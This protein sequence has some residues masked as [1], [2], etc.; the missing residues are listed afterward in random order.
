MNDDN[1]IGRDPMGRLPFWAAG[2]DVDLDYGAYSD[3][4]LQALFADM[5]V[6]ERGIRTALVG[7]KRRHRELV[8]LLTEQ[9]RAVYGRNLKGR[10]STKW[11]SGA[12]GDQA[13]VL[14]PGRTWGDKDRRYSLRETETWTGIQTQLNAAMPNGYANP[15]REASPDTVLEVCDVCGAPIVNGKRG[16]QRRYC[17]RD[18]SHKQ[19]NHNARRRADPEKSVKARVA[20]EQQPGFVPEFNL[21]TV[22]VWMV[23]DI[24][25]QDWLRF[26][27]RPGAGF[28]IETMQAIS[29]I[30]TVVAQRQIVDDSFD[31]SQEAVAAA[32]A[33]MFRKQADRK[34]TFRYLAGG[35][36]RVDVPINGPA[37]P[38]PYRPAFSPVKLD[39]RVPP[40]WMTDL[41]P[42]C[43]PDSSRPEAETVTQMRTSRSRRA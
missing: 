22:H 38:F 21:G 41:P 19:I 10:W 1:R 9:Q 42:N 13:D 14:E 31:W 12:G 29:H 37:A 30:F 15:R 5:G 3:D 28:L 32:E 18:G 27:R 2:K 11:V 17:M 26:S 25:T 6:L 35:W 4:E 43:D 40:A 34:A 20:Y 16:Q 33:T 39:W 8:D 36:P 24:A 7:T 23:G